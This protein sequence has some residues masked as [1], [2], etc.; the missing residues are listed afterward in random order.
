M[1]EDQKSKATLDKEREQRIQ[2]RRERIQQKIA[3][4]HLG[5]ESHGEPKQRWAEESW[6]YLQCIP[7]SSLTLEHGCRRRMLPP[8]ARERKSKT[9]FSR[10]EAWK[11]SRT[12]AEGNEHEN[13]QERE[14]QKGERER[15]SSARRAWLARFAAERNDEVTQV[16]VET[17]EREM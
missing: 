5:G 10:V 14:G 13:T 3:S 12:V 6:G 15:N 16:R 7:R 1:D 8:S 2:A 17:D 4:A 11:R 9:S